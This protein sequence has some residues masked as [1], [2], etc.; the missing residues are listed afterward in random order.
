MKKIILLLLISSSVWAQQPKNKY[1][2]NEFILIQK[3]EDQEKKYNEVIKGP[4]QN[5]APTALNDFRA[6]LALAWLFKGNVARYQYYKSTSPKFSYRQALYLGY[7]VEKL[8][9]E[10]KDYANAEKISKALLDDLTK[11]KMDGDAVRPSVLFE[12]NAAANAKLGN[13]DVAKKMIAKSSEDKSSESRLIKYFKDMQA[14][15]LNRQAMVMLAAGE[16]Q[17]AYDVL[18]KAFK[19]AESNSYMVETFKEAF[20]KVKGTDQGFDAYLKSLKAEAYQKYYKEVETHYVSA[21]SKTITGKFPDPSGGSEMITSFE[22]KTPLESVAMKNLD[23]KTVNL[24]DYKGKILVLDFWTTLCTPCVAAFAGFEKVVSDYKKD[25]LQLFVVNIFEE[26][27][28]V[29]AFAAQKPV[30][31]SVLQDQ[32]NTAYNVAATPTKIIFDSMGNIR[33][34][35]S[36]YAG[37]TDREYYKLKAMV[38]ITKARS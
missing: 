31:L 5:L 32:E 21:P 26:N 25:D 6:E 24:G 30:T 38:E 16:Y 29:K 9:D 19:E 27:A 13:V 28:A 4:A 7:A 14:N 3:V 36:G 37:S 11:G 17:K 34:F 12:V 10:K 2:I 23:G 8:L 1:S 22:A 20:K 18:D 15:Y 33:F 35:S